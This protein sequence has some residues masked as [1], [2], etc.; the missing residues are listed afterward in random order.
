MWFKAAL[1]NAINDIGK[2]KEKIDKK[3]WEFQYSDVTDGLYAIV[4]VKDFYINYIYDPTKYLNHNLND[5]Q[6]E[7]LEMLM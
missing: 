1:L 3:I 2:E 4:N 7:G 5:R 6:N